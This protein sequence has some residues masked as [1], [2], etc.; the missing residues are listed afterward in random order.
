MSRLLKE[1]VIE[2]E[3]EPLLC[4]AARCNIVCR[5]IALL[6]PSLS[7]QHFSRLGHK[8]CVIELLNIGNKKENS[9]LSLDLNQEDRSGFSP[10]VLAVY[11]GHTDVVVALT[12]RFVL[13]TS[14]F[15]ISSFPVGWI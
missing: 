7:T 12:K 15:F 14:T 11:G 6:N 1:G 10:L 2:E 4:L 13:V 8:E 5:Q 9:N 3:E